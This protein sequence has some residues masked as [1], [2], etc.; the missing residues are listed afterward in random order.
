MQ[1]TTRAHKGLWCSLSSERPVRVTAVNMS[2]VAIPAPTDA[3]VNATSTASMTTK[4]LADSRPKIPVIMIT[5]NRSRMRTMAMAVMTRKI[6]RTKLTRN[7]MTLPP[8]Y[9]HCCSSAERDR[10]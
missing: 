2:K 9:L 3:S 5:A 7:S 6:N 8:L 4:K 10:F 1:T